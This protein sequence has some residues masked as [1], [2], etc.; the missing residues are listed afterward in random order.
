MTFADGCVKFNKH[1]WHFILVNL[2]FPHYL[3]DWNNKVKKVNLCPYMRHVLAGL[4]LVA[5]VVPWRQLPDRVQDYAWVV[6]AQL[7]FLALV[8]MVSFFIDLASTGIHPFLESVAIGFV[9]GNILALI[10]GLFIFGCMA[11]KDVIDDR[12]RKERKPNR[13]KGLIK[14]YMNSKHEKIC[15]CVEFVED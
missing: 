14:T 13:T 4:F 10:G 6:Q 5:F 12:P 3:L 11:V 15:P 9:G 2:V 7:I 8:I 1:S